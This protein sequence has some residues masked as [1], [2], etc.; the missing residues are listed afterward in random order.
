MA[1]ISERTADW[2]GVRYLKKL[3]NEEE[4]A[5]RFEDATWHCEHHNYDLNYIGK[6]ALSELPEDTGYKVVLTGEGADENFA[7]YP[8]YLPDFLR[9]P[10]HSGKFT[11]LSDSERK[12]FYAEKETEVAEYYT[13]VGAEAFNRAPSAASRMLNNIT[14]PASMSA[15]HPDCF[16]NA[17]KSTFPQD[18]LTTIANATPDHIRSSMM[19]SWHPLHSAL[20]AWSKGHLTNNFL[21]CLGDRTEMA[22][23]IEART[24][25]LDHHLTEYV[26]GLPPSVKVRYSDSDQSGG[27]PE[28]TE[29]WI[30][31]EAARPFITDEL[32]KRKKFPYSAPTVWPKD[33]PIHKLFRRL[34]TQENVERLGFVDWLKV[35]DNLEIAFEKGDVRAMRGCYVVGQWVVIGERFGIARA[36]VD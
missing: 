17:A 9:E 15:F 33:G 13:S 5:N 6:F 22:H 2:L 3:M 4:L 30:L 32:Y 25:F 31:R 14:T 26:N 19:N 35:K 12:R 11:T 20:Y 8:T 18:S 1:D 21:S 28:F 24:P 10:D 27:K 34:L 29:K 23:S 16:A 7:G 36:E